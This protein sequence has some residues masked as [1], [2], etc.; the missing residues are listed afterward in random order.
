MRARHVDMLSCLFVLAV[1][2]AAL[3][4]GGCTD[5]GGGAQGEGPG[6]QVSQTGTFAEA[7]P[8]WAPPARDAQG[9]VVCPYAPGAPVMAYTFRSSGTDAEAVQ[10]SG[11]FSCK[12]GKPVAI[13]V[14]AQ[15]INRSNIGLVVASITAD[16]KS[17]LAVR[18]ARVAEEVT[19]AIEEI[20]RRA[21]CAAVPAACVGL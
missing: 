20:V 13:N 3:L 10:F 1:M 15:G 2:T 12:D 19:P 16:I 14:S 4:L 5:F 8:Q 9:N 11:E 7:R 18:D 6:D 21:L 17:A